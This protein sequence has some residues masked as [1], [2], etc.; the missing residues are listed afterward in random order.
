VLE[1][2]SVAQHALEEPKK[3]RKQAHAQV[4]GMP[5]PCCTDGDGQLVG[6]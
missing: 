5:H 3:G 1:V 2:V 4:A 6:E